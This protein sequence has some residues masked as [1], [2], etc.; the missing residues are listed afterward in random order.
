MTKK[1]CKHSAE[2][3]EFSETCFYNTSC[4]IKDDYERKTRVG[5]IKSSRAKF[6]KCK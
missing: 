3:S 2:C 6:T 5:F 4:G 1:L